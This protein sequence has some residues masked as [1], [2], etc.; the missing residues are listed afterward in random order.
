MVFGDV[1]DDICLKLISKY[2]EKVLV[3]LAI[4]ERGISCKKAAITSE[5]YREE[6][7]TKYL[8]PFYKKCH[9]DEEYVF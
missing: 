8:V 5:V 6:C 1:P 3:W 2:P 9:H 4:S 7:L